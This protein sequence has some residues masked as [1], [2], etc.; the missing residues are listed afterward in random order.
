L[1]LDRRPGGNDD[2][3]RNNSLHRHINVDFFPQ[4]KYIL[5]RCQ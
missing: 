4:I 5:T 1:L 2:N 3:M